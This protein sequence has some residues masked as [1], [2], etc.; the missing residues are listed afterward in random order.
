MKRGDNMEPLF[1]LVKLKR[2][3]LY[4]TKDELQRYF[5]DREHIP[6]EEGDIYNIPAEE[7]EEIWRRSKAMLRA[8]AMKERMDK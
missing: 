7:L 1:Y 2:W 5:P 8:R 4:F 3:S 6:I